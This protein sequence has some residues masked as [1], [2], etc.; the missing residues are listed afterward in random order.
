MQTVGVK[1]L[2][3]R[4][5]AYLRTVAQGETVLVTDRGE[6]VAEIIA[7]RVGET[8]GPQQRVLAQLDRLGVLTA[9]KVAPGQRLPRRRPAAPLVDILRDLDEARGER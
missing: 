7:P 8:A 9:A 3:N 6:I 4:L 1:E 2:K 5:S